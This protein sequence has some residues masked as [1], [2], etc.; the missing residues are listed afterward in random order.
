M[1]THRIVLP[2]NSTPLNGMPAKSTPLNNI[3]LDGTYIIIN[4][5]RIS[6]IDTHGETRWGIFNLLSMINERYGHVTVSTWIQLIYGLTI[7]FLVIWTMMC[8]ALLAIRYVRRTRLQILE[9]YQTTL[10]YALIL[11]AVSHGSGIF[12]L[13]ILFLFVTLK[14][15]RNTQDLIKSSLRWLDVLV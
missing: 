8:P 4:N 10:W 14:G 9:L 11:F 2:P 1:S 6:T 13:V 3:R 15:F 5:P 7:R 12:M